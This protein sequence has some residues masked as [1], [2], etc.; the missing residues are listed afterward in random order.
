MTRK[1]YWWRVRCR[2]ARTSCRARVTLCKRPEEYVKPK[3]CGVCRGPLV[4]D[5]YRQSKREGRKY[6]CSCNGRLWKHR[7]GSPFCVHSK[8]AKM[9][10]R[11]GDQDGPAYQTWKETGVPF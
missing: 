7:R 10:F 5:A 4:V 2:C 9:G 6:K 8:A 1:G 11:Y 3:R